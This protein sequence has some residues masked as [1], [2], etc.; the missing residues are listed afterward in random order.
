[1]TEQFRGIT[2]DLSRQGYTEAARRTGFLQHELEQESL[3]P[4]SLR[5]GNRIGTDEQ[6]GDWFKRLMKKRHLSQRQLAEKAG[7]DHSTISRFLN[8]S[9]SSLTVGTFASMVI[10]LDIQPDTYA[11]VIERIV[12]DK[13][14]DNLLYV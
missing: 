8:N 7:I 5:N 2:R 3:I 1:M 10:A 11:E 12:K 14:P 6:V 13:K 4:E 9:T